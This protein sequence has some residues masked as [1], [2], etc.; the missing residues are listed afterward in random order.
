MLNQ[1]LNFGYF[2]GVDLDPNIK[3]G[4]VQELANLPVLNS[5]SIGWHPNYVELLR[6]DEEG[7]D[8]DR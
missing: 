1:N 5:L 3:R 8:N 2:D 4:I 7:D 6:E